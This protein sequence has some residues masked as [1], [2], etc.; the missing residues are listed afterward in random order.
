MAR[1]FSKILR[2]NFYKYSYF[3]SRKELSNKNGGYRDSGRDDSFW[4]RFLNFFKGPKW[5]PTQKNFGRFLANTLF[6]IYCLLVYPL[7]L[8]NTTYFCYNVTT[9]PKQIECS[10]FFFSWT[11]TDKLEFTEWSQVQQMFHCEENAILRWRIMIAPP[12]PALIREGAL[13]K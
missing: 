1:S 9:K 4:L 11:K 7:T 6:W 8:I 13:L 12:P 5:A 10:V 3:Y 2:S